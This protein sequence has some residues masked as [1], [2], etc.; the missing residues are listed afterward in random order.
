MIEQSRALCVAAPV[1]ARALCLLARVRVGRS[2][3]S[4]P[5]P[6]RTQK[7]P[8]RR[9]GQLTH[10]Y[11]WAGSLGGVIV[12]EPADANFCF[13]DDA[14][15]AVTERCGRCHPHRHRQ[16]ESPVPWSCAHA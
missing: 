15:N 5:T 14:A 7:P 12:E 11:A 2:A 10:Q 13:S 8:R 3:L 16:T 6:P 9:A 1:V 4:Y